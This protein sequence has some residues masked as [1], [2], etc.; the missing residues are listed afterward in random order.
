M[1]DNPAPMPDAERLTLQRLEQ[2]IKAADYF[3]DVNRLPLIYVAGAN[4]TRAT[5]SLLIARATHSLAAALN[6]LDEGATKGSL[7]EVREGLQRFRALLD[8]WVKRK[9][10]QRVIDPD[11]ETYIKECCNIHEQEVRRPFLE[12]VLSY[13]EGRLGRGED[14]LD[15]YRDYAREAERAGYLPTVPYIEDESIMQGLYARFQNAP[16]IGAA[17]PGLTE[18]EHDPRLTEE[19]HD[20]LSRAVKLI[21]DGIREHRRRLEATD[22]ENSMTITGRAGT[23]PAGERKNAARGADWEQQANPSQTEGMENRPI[24]TVIARSGGPRLNQLKRDLLQ[25]AY[26]LKALD[27]RSLRSRKKVVEKADPAKEPTNGNIN[28]AFRDL[29]NAGFFGSAI[30][31]DGGVWLTAKGR[32]IVEEQMAKKRQA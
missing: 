23:M 22:Q 4:F 31:R 14:I 26:I 12:A 29:I 25:A 20:R 8:H 9:E 17:P 7:I 24:D 27:E 18:E 19:E 10:W 13:V 6:S 3:S 30:G 16:V 5:H 15:K 32:E 1:S 21:A 11:G 28:R 2:L